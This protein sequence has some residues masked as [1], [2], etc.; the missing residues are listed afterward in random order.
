MAEYLLIESRGLPLRIERRRILLR[1]GERVG[2]SGQQSYS[3]SDPK[4]GVCGAAV[5][6]G[7]TASGAGRLWRFEIPQDG[8]ALKKPARASWETVLGTTAIQV[9]VVR[10]EAGHKT[11]W[12]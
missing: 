2:G 4:C 7:P 9:V 12:H 6:A 8:F 11:L 10:L 3:F 1:S 5:S